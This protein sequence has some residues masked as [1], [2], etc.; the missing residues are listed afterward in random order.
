MLPTLLPR[1]QQ[2][3]KERPISDERLPGDGLVLHARIQVA[4]R[5]CENPEVP[6]ADELQTMVLAMREKGVKRDRSEC[7]DSRM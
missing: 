2:F 1:H 3:V 7:R 4:V 6:T 5:L